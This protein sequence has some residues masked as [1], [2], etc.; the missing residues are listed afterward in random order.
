MEA[1]A[2][3]CGLLT[4]IFLPVIY[5]QAKGKKKIAYSIG[6]VGIILYIFVKPV[7]YIANGMSGYSFKLSSLW[8]MVLMLYIVAKNFDLLLERKGNSKKN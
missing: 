4:F 5:I 3:Y 6:L 2:F 1:P 8:V 7:R